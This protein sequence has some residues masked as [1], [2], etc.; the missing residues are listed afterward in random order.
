MKQSRYAFKIQNTSL[1]ESIECTLFDNKSRGDKNCHKNLILT[2]ANKLFSYDNVINNLIEKEVKISKVCVYSNN[3]LQKRLS[4]IL[5]H[6]DG[7]GQSCNVP[8]STDENE[9]L[10]CEL[11]VKTDKLTIDVLPNSFIVFYAYEDCIENPIDS[12]AKEEML[13]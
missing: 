13:K 11:N 1:T 8:V 3:V 4:L 5:S 6:G 2:N 12:A 9:E 10:T 7:N